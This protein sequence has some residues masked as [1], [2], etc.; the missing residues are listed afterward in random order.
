LGIELYKLPV[1]PRQMLAEPFV[2]LL[3]EKIN[4][5]IEAAVGRLSNKA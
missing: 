1:Y 5:S 2:P 3:A 4:E